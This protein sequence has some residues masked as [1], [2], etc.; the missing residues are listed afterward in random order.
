MST[1]IDSPIPMPKTSMSVARVR[2]PVVGVSRE[3]NH[4]PE[5]ITTN[6]LIGK[7]L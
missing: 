4:S 5:A 7:I 2:Y 1:C 3:S 6:P